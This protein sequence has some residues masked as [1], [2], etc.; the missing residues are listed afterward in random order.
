M[1]A[2]AVR[3]ELNKA[4]QFP[5]ELRE[6]VKLRNLTMIDGEYYVVPQ[7]IGLPEI[8]AVVAVG[9]TLDEAMEKV[10]GYAEKVEGYF[11]DVFPDALD[12]GQEEIKKLNSIGIRI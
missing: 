10:K 3:L 2:Q 11:L 9:N 12:G 6:N 5:E 4:V 1:T 7:S 8:G